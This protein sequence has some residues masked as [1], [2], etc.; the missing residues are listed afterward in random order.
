MHLQGKCTTLRFTLAS[1][2]PQAG[3]ISQPTRDFG[4]N[5]NRTVLIQK[6]ES[7]QRNSLFRLKE[8]FFFFFG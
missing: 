5:N 4:G 8:D 3:V 7:F 1:P 6:P 2:L